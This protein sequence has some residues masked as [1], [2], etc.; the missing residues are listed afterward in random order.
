VKR[1]LESALEALAD[2]MGIE[3]FPGAAAPTLEMRAIQ[4]LAMVMG[5]LPHE[6][7]EPDTEGWWA[8]GKSGRKG[9]KQVEWFY[10]STFDDGTPPSI[11]VAEIQ[12]FVPVYKFSKPLMWWWG[13]IKVP[14][15]GDV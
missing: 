10:V 11:W 3:R 2:K 7:K 6:T 13:P 15:D 9:G 8:R 4:A 1:E 14:F 5:S 12:D